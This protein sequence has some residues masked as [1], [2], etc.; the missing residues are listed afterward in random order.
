[1]L[2]Q[3]TP[4]EEV[5]L[6][7]TDTVCP[8]FYSFMI[9]NY[10]NTEYID[11]KNPVKVVINF[12]DYILC[13]RST[14]FISSYL[15]RDNQDYVN[16]QL[17]LYSYHYGDV[18][19]NLPKYLESNRLVFN[20]FQHDSV[21]TMLKICSLSKIS[22]IDF[23]LTVPT[24]TVLEQTPYTLTFDL[25][26]D[27]A[28]CNNYPYRVIRNLSCVDFKRKLMTDEKFKD[29]FVRQLQ[30]VFSKYTHGLVIEDELM[31]YLLENTDRRSDVICKVFLYAY[32]S[33]N[34]LNCVIDTYN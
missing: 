15:G 25:N 20:W 9:R 18:V 4:S 33:M 12:K 17:F 5:C 30:R 24:V 19:K 6:R 22:L 32:L 1:M 3:N 26:T 7:I 10:I 23:E 14:G 13:E 16:A 29:K 11:L 21:V 27:L 2:T 8:S 28:A 31:S 34:K